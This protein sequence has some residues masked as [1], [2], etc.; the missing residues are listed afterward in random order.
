MHNFFYSIITFIFAILFIL[1]G[2][3]GVMIPWSADIRTGL[4]QFILEDSLAISLFGFAGIVIGLAMAIHVLLNARRQ[5]Y[6]LR[7]GNKSVTIDETVVK[8]YV[9][10]YW[11]QLFPNN[12]IPNR[13]AIK[14]NI[15]YIHADFPY[16]PIEQQRPLLERVRQDLKSRFKKSMGYTEDFH[17]YA[18]FQP[19]P[20][21]EVSK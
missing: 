10:L 2:I 4:V 21:K 19:E 16:L 3:V 7:S 8:Q 17:L 9:D 1:V 5:C 14:N 20:K 12:D 18:S 11:K 15:I 6:H 13:L